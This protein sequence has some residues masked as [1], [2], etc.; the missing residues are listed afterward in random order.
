MTPKISAKQVASFIWKIARSFPL[1]LGA[2]ILTAFVWAIDVSLRPYILKIILNRVVETPAS[3]V[4]GTLF[5]PGV[6]YIGMGFF[7]AVVFRIYGYFVEIKMI[8]S[9]RKNIADLIF[10]D[11]LRQSHEYY[12]HHYSGS[13]SSKINDLA[14]GVPDVVQ[15]FMDRLFS[16]FLALIIAIVTLSFVN[17]KFGFLTFIWAS[18]FCLSSYFFSKKISHL[19]A[20]WSEWG[21]TIVGKIVDSLSNILSVRLFAR[22]KLEI[23]SLQETV[24]KSVQAEQRLQWIKFWL[25]VFNNF[26]FTLL[27]ALNLY[28]LIKGR[29]EGWVTMGDFVLVLSINIAIDSFLW[30]LARQFSQ[31]SK[32]FGKIT[33]AL[34]TLLVTPEIKDSPQAKPLIISKGEI[35]FESVHFHYKEAEPLFQ[36]KSVTL[37]PGQKTGLVGYSGSG[38]TT[39]VSLILRLFDVTSGHILIDGQNIR[40]ITQA[41]LHEAIGMIPQDPSLF[42]RSLMENIRYGRPEATEREII[43]AAKKAHAHE[44][45]KDLPKGYDSLVGERGVKLSGGQRQRIAIARTILKNAPILILDE[46]TS[47]LD[48]VT[49]SYIQDSLWEV[50]EGKTTIVIAHRLSTLLHMDRILV[51]DKGKIVEDGTHKILLTKGGVYKNLWD[52]QV[53][54]FLGDVRERTL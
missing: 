40:E 14:S 9:M 21:A 26:S 32:D 30:E 46:A 48:S 2:M 8:P 31:F 54:G 49:E 23:A 47:Q 16:H 36:K 11:L 13:L 42:H 17:I 29:Y 19:S 50:M 44:F 45:I 39:F 4:F 27:L 10:K 52:A 25:W 22:E 12:Q 24:N 37:Y 6:A 1:G 43:E 38:K 15:I 51:F 28:F 5:L 53:G 34:K 41:S 33:Q 18:L 7:M 20:E 3:D 35:V